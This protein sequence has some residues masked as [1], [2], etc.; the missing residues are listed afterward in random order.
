MDKRLRTSPT[1]AFALLLLAMG[2]VGLFGHLR[3]ASAVSMTT[4]AAAPTLPQMLDDTA[5]ATASPAQDGTR[6]RR[7]SLSM[8]YFS[9]AR[10]L[11]P[12]S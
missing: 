4:A 7:H 11:R 1:V 12:G 3:A 8:P 10:L 5:A 2:T 9:F 6:A